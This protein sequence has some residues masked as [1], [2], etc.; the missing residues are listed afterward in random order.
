MKDKDVVVALSA[1]AQES[2]LAIF[3]ALIVA[4]PTG[5]TPSVLADALKLPPATLSFHLKE[6]THAQLLTQERQGRYLIYRVNIP[7][8]NEVLG[9]LTKNCCQGEGICVDLPNIDCSC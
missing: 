1:L 7:G 5:R 9:Y 6:L 3:R 8:M 2:R 4:G